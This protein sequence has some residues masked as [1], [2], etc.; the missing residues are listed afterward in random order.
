MAADRSPYGSGLQ[1]DAEF[2]SIAAY[3]KNL[4]AVTDYIPAFT[5]LNEILFNA[6]PA[7][8]ISGQHA[9]VRR[10]GPDAIDPLEE[11]L[12]A[13]LMLETRDT[14]SLQLFVQA[15]LRSEKE[16]KRELTKAGGEVR[17]LTVHSAKGLEAPIVIIPDLARNP[18]KQ[19]NTP[20]LYWNEDGLPL[21]SGSGLEAPMITAAKENAKLAQEE[22]NRR[23][24]YVAL[25]RAR[26]VLILCGIAKPDAKEEPPWHRF[27]RAGMEELKAE[28]VTENGKELLRYGDK[29]AFGP[30]PKAQDEM[31]SP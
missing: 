19:G 23:L 31:K 2:K 27:C 5:L 10:L 24:L 18:T 12:S 25:T 6:C 11:L 28:T 7:D 8:A 20:V 13:A 26:D 21:S 16:S 1:A 22:E 30:L 3:L 4:L 15:I 17:I 29:S 9:L 14:P